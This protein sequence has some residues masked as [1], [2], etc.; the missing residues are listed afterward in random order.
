MYLGIDKDKYIVYDGY[1]HWGARAV[2]PTPYLFP[3]KVGETPEEALNLLKAE[4]PAWYEKLL[5]RE[6]GFDP[7]SMVRRGRIYELDRPQT[8]C[9]V[10]PASEAEREEARKNGGVVVKQ[11]AL[12]QRYPLSVRV[13]STQRFA[14]VGSSTVYSMWR[15][16]SSDYTYFTEELVTMRPLYFLGALPDLSL[17]NIP[18]QW[19][20]MIQESVGKVADSMYRANADS[21]I[22]LC[23]H[24]ASASLCAYF[25]EDIPRLNKIDLGPLAKM[26]EDAKR[27]VI[28][29]CARTLADLHSRLKPN[30]QMHTDCRP[31]C[32]RDAELAVQCLSCILADLGYTRSP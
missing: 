17:D 28:A 3:I 7:I 25:Q 2:F 13:P 24:A 9:H 32:D 29:D 4:K 12:Y 11:L 31:I 23:R 16:V 5:F 20:T 22:E 30:M 14:A 10:C 21:I 27:R 6:D 15:I 26:A 8:G 19:R 18:E 1:V